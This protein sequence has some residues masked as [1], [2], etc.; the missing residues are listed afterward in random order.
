MACKCYIVPPQ[1]LQGIADSTDNDDNVRHRARGA[2]EARNRTQASRKDRI[3]RVCQ[4]HRS[5]NRPSAFIPQQLL[6][7][8]S[9]SQDVDENTRSRAKRDLEH[10]KKRGEGQQQPI[11]KDGP[12]RAVYD[13]KNS[14][15][16][17]QLPGDLVRYAALFIFQIFV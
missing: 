6:E 5:T 14:M 11:T 4:G 2:I 7:R 10:A 3:T 13:M 9:N 12:Y 1:L 16:E 17:Q 8:L 15:N